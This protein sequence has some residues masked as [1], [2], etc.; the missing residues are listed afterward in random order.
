MLED[1]LG[2]QHCCIQMW[3]EVLCFIS[4]YHRNNIYILFPEKGFN[5]GEVAKA[6]CSTSSITMLAITAETGETHSCT[7]NLLIEGAVV[8]KLC[9]FEA[10]KQQMNNILHRQKSSLSLG[11][12]FSESLLHNL[13]PLTPMSDYKT[14]FLLTISRQCYADKWWE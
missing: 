7:K 3:K 1:E 12:I 5:C 2:R 8:C 10:K 13:N 4:R 11:S 9:G 6:L 14:E